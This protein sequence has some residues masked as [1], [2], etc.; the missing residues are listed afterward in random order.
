MT[1]T[2]VR[3]KNPLEMVGFIKS[4][5]T[6]CCFISMRTETE[7][8]MRKTGNPY[9][10]TVKVSRRNGLVNVNYVA[11]VERK[12]KELTG[13]KTE[14]TPGQTWYIHDTTVEGKPLPLC[15]SKKPVKR[16]GKIEPYLQYYPHRTIGEDTFFLNGHQLSEAEVLDMQKFVIEDTRPEYKPTVITLMME[17]IRE[18]KARKITMLNSTFSRIVEGVLSSVK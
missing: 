4:I 18:L 17:S 5:G 8:K 1:N 7:V 12:L 9:F 14:Y 6:T 3:I 16:T 10:G 15:Y 13:E 2:T 11:S